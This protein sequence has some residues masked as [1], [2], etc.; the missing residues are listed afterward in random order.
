[1]T[2]GSPPQRAAGLCPCTPRLRSGRRGSAP[3]PRACAAGGR[4]L[5]CTRW[6]FTPGPEM[7]PHLSSPA[8]GTGAWVFFPSFMRYDTARQNG[9]GLVG[10]GA[11]WWAP[12]YCSPAQKA[13]GMMTP[14]AFLCF[15]S[16]FWLRLCSLSASWGCLCGAGVVSRRW[17]SARGSLWV[18][19][20]GTVRYG[21]V[22]AVQTRPAPGFYVPSSCAA[23]SP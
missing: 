8:G 1:M 23:R 5:P 13:A 22:R 7:L 14:A 20:G 12:A 18:F 9:S 17:F 3:A 6:G 15:C 16:V 19:G 2:A 10:V 21:S 4:A 11:N